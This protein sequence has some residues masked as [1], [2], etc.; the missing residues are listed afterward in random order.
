MLKVTKQGLLDGKAFR[1]ASRYDHDSAIYRLREV[2][3]SEFSDKFYKIDH[4][5]LF[6]RSEPIDESYFSYHCSVDKLGTR[7]V[8]LHT[9]LL[10]KQCK[11]KF[12]F[13]DL[14]YVK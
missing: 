6:N 12:Q 5:H 10:G 11:A 1:V 3:K 13:K 9:W 7:S 2:P 14:E 4:G 8:S